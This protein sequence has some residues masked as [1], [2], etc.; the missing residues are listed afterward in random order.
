MSTPW[1]WYKDEPW[2]LKCLLDE[3]GTTAPLLKPQGPWD[4]SDADGRCGHCESCCAP[5]CDMDEHKREEKHY[6]R[7]F[8]IYRDYGREAF[9]QFARDYS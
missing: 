4:H 8:S 9:V 7:E 1:K 6:A 3:L 2:C 5:L